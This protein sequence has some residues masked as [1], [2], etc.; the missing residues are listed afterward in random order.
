M[1]RQA[2]ALGRTGTVLLAVSLALL[3]VSFIPAGQQGYPS[4]GEQYLAPL[5]FSYSGYV[6]YLNPQRGIRVNVTADRELVVYVFRNSSVSIFNWISTHLPDPS[7]YTQQ[8]ET[9]MLDAFLGNQTS[10]IAY[11]TNVTG[12][13]QVDYVPSEVEET[14]LIFANYGNTTATY[15]YE[16]SI[17]SALAPSAKLQTVAA[18]TSP[19]GL[20]LAAPWIISTVRKKRHTTPKKS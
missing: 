17:M 4:S 1:S 13:A 18:I 11:E 19:L 12:Q 2:A 6:L 7:N 16:V 20:I 3:L 14:T 5:H 8:D 10:L 9:F 15:E